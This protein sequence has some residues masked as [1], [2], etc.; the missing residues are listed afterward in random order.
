MARIAHG[1]LT[2]NTVATV[3]LDSDFG[4]VEVLNRN[5]VAEIYFTV[6]GAVPTVG[7]ADTEVLP[8]ALGSVDVASIAS[9]PTVVKLISTGAA[10]YSVRGS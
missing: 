5:G 8:A 9:G 10:T 2:P 4:S 7:G 6:D 3:T 1:T